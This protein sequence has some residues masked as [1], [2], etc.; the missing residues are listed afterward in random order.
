MIVMEVEVYEKEVL[1]E[2]PDDSDEDIREWRKVYKYATFF[3]ENNFVIEEDG[4]EQIILT[5]NDKQFVIK[6]NY[7]EFIQK[8]KDLL[9][10]NYE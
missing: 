9:E 7:T 3:L 10:D 6:G 5:T 1:Y 2:S 4:E 8:I